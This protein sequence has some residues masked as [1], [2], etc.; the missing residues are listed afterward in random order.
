MTIEIEQMSARLIEVKLNY[1]YLI[2]MDFYRAISA[3]YKICIM[4]TFLSRS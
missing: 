3:I 2:R 4:Q 1:C